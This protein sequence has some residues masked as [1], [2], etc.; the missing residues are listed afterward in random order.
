LG[1]TIDSR[2]TRNHEIA[3]GGGQMTSAAE[4]A[5]W[6]ERI[7]ILREMDVDAALRLVAGIAP[8][9][10]PENRRNAEAGLHKARA[11]KSMRRFF[12]K[13]QIQASK[14]WLKKN[15]FTTKVR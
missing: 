5:A 4:I 2:K 3:T 7:R 15:D 8:Q 11:H 10:L 13:E 9:D 12:T 1:V 14:R 6:K